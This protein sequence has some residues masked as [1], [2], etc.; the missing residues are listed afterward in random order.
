VDQSSPDYVIT[1]GSD[2]SL[3][4]RFPIVD[5]ALNKKRKRKKKETAGKH[6]G[7]VCVITQRVTLMT[8]SSV[9]FCWDGNT[10][11]AGVLVG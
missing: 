8:K 3:Q 9:I 4:R 7:R 11:H 2:R 5:L 6:K 1:R 10:T